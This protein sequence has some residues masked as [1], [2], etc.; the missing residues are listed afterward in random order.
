MIAVPANLRNDKATGSDSQEVLVKYS[1]IL[2]KN[3]GDSAQS[4][5]RSSK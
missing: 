4:S 3:L 2:M 5:I 1:Q